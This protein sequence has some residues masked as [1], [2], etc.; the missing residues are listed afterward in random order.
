MD[1]KE[2][3]L[4]DDTLAIWGG[5]FGRTSFCHGRLTDEAY[6]R[7]HHPQAFA[8]WMAGGGVKAGPATERR[9]TSGSTS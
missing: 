7:D 9:T 2:R 4:L 5:E 8:I 1:V 6:G 3:G